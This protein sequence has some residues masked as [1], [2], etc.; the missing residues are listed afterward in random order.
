[1]NKE[2]VTNRYTTEEHITDNAGDTAV[3]TEPRIGAIVRDTV[4]G[5]AVAATLLSSIYTV[6]E[7]HVAVVKRFSE[8]KYQVEPGLH[9]KAPIVDSLESMEV[10]T[11]KNVEE[12][13]PVATAEQMPSHATVSVNWTVNRAE[14]ID[15][16][17]QYGGLDQ[18]ESRILDPKIKSGS[19]EAISKHTAEEI[20]RNRNVV[21][22]KIQDAIITAMEPYPIVI[23]SVQLEN[24][25]FPMTYTNAIEAKQVAL[26]EAVKEEHKLERQRLEAQRQ[27]NTAE[28]EKQSRMKAA[29]GVAYQT[30]TEAKAE[31]EAIRLIGIANAGKIQAMATALATNPQVI[32][33]EQV[34]RWQGNVPTTVMGDGQSIMWQMKGTK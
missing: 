11:R 34:K 23:N 27:V 9:F 31:A 19:K 32:E 3:Y 13:I 7:G 1:M 24:I 14:A 2:V 12:H 26:Q 33:Y 30:E 6:E 29:D 15:I 25:T 18:F 8:A 22:T 21:I 4:L 28:A 10:R 5:L 17:K 16:F 20:I